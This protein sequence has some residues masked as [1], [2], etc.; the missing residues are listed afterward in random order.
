MSTSDLHPLNALFFF[1]YCRP[2]LAKSI[3]RFSREREIT[4]KAPIVPCLYRLCC[5]RLVCYFYIKKIK[6][7][8]SRIWYLNCWIWKEDERT[9]GLMKARMLPYFQ[10]EE[11]WCH[12]WHHQVRSVVQSNAP[13]HAP[14]T[15]FALTPINA[16]HA[17]NSRDL[18]PTRKHYCTHSV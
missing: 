10:I 17:D 9:C 8:N 1:I 13:T 15:L 11:G 16:G 18:T 4:R 2:R 3:T 12:H 14:S 7:K 5:F 6:R